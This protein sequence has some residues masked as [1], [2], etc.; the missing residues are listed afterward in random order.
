M[1]KLFYYFIK[2]YCPVEKLLCA[3]RKSM[4]LMFCT[5]H[6]KGREAARSFSPHHFP[7][8]LSLTSFGTLSSNFHGIFSINRYNSIKALEENK[9]KKCD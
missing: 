3:P 4:S 5:F 8:Y 9:T 1:L 6:C 2:T 7:K